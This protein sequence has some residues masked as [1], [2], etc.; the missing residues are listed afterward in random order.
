M[1]LYDEIQ[2]KADLRRFIEQVLQSPGLSSGNPTVVEGPQGEPGPPGPEGPAG[3]TGATGSKGETGA[4]GATGATGP[5]G[6]KGA[7]GATG[8]TGPEGPAGPSGPS[9]WGRVSS[10]GTKESGVGYTVKHVS[11]GKYE[12]TLTTA[13]GEKPSWVA[14][15]TAESFE[16]SAATNPTSPTVCVVTTRELKTGTLIDVGFSFQVM[17]E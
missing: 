4:T 3:A 15:P 12:L 9:A 11:T 2:N 13:L 10:T 8:A 1:S 16:R 14:T 17:G 7:T 5:E 6:P